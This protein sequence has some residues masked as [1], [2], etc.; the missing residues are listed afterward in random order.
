[1]ATKMMV[2]LLAFTFGGRWIDQHYEL[3][4]PVATLVGA[5]LGSG[6]AIYSMI[7]DLLK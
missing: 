4:F 5:L 7:R 6:I 3:A 1:M 2:I